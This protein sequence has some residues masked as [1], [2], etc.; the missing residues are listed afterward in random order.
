MQ[1]FGEKGKHTRVAVGA[2]SLPFDSSVE[3]DF[4]VEAF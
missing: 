3:I 1:L 2:N 4:L